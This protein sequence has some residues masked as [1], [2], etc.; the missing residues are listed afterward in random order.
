MGSK[1]S[2]TTTTQQQQTY[3]PT[4]APQIQSALAQGQAAAQ[5]PFNI[6]QAPV[7]GF[8]QDQQNAFQNVNNAQ[9]MAQPYIN[10]A[11]QDFSPQG[12]QNFLNPYASNVMAQMQNI[13]GQQQQ[14]ATGQLTQAAGGVGA[15]R[16][17]VGQGELANQQGLAAG[18]TMS[19][20]YNNAVQ[21]AQGAGYGTAALGSQAQNA[22][23]QGAQAQLGTGGLQQQLSQA[24]MNSPYQWQ[25]AQAAFPYQQAQFNAGITGA[26]APGL[27][28]TTSGTGSTTGPAPSMLSQ[29]LGLGTAAAGVAGGTG[30]FGSGSGSGGKGANPSAAGTPGS[31]YYG[32]VN[33]GG[34]ARGGDV[35][36]D[37]GG[38]TNPYGLPSGFNDKPI[39][40]DQESIVPKEALTP[41]RPNIPQL[42]LNPPAA[43]GG[44]GGGSAVGDVAKIAQM[45]MMFAKRGGRVGY[46]E[47]GEV[48]SSPEDFMRDLR[49]SPTGSARID[50]EYPPMKEFLK[51]LPPDVER[52][53]EGGPVIRLRK[54]KASDLISN[55]GGAVNPYAFAAGG[56][57]DVIN[58]DE[59]YRMADQPSV[60]AWRSGADEAM[61]FAPTGGTRSGND[62]P[63]PLDTAQWPSGPIGG[64][65]DAG[66]AV[67]A[68]A[69]GNASAPGA[70]PPEVPPPQ[71]G[72]KRDHDRFIDSPWA[73]LMAAGLGI[74]GGTSPFA[75]VNI[76]QGGLQG[77]K[78]LQEQRGSAQKDETIDQAAKRL[79][80]EAKHHEDQYSRMTPGQKETLA[81]HKS[82]MAL[83]ENKPI[84]VGI[85]AMGHDIL[86]I[87]DKDTGAYVDP[88]TRKPVQ[89]PNARPPS[90]NIPQGGK[91]DDAAL[92]P[93]AQLTE[94]VDIPEGVDKTVLA[95]ISPDVAKTVRAIDE[96]RANL[97][98]IPMKDR[99]AYLKL[100]NEYDPAWD[101]NLY[102]LRK[103]QN[104]DMS[105]QGNAGKMILAVNQLLPHLKKASDDA[106][107][108]NNTGYP[109]ANTIKNWWLTQTGDPR[110]KQFEQV[111]EVAAMDVAR[112]LR[113]SGQ[114]AEK[115]IDFWRQ[116]FASADSPKTM[117]GL[118][119][120]LA[121]DLMG[122][123]IGSIQQSYRMNMRKEPPDFV[124]KE[125]KEALAGIK[126]RQQPAQPQ[127]VPAAGAPVPAAG[128]AA[129]AKPPTVVQNGHTYTLQPDGSYK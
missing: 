59:P 90:Y 111:R 66:A 76:G 86:G 98:S 3:N 55:R 20:L 30:M 102:S 116:S 27:G 104:D 105:T 58:P 45:A 122:A 39:N 115:D 47:G 23:L 12:A 37:E 61:K 29:I 22:A 13:F 87:R 33:S 101:Q 63:S 51:A 15:D 96:G 120:Q 54:N 28:G 38:S 34:Y 9:G 74:A 24:Q 49:R 114:M 68:F 52:G 41:I 26:L 80:L 18:Q 72:S 19:G 92:P 123:R 14:Q 36:Y 85:D 40:V 31:P 95:R 4:G 50:P 56:D 118:I 129:P 60:N 62:K 121:D 88:I 73:A 108:L 21:Q 65:S 110:V 46:A 100:V 8:S 6:P 69:P 43:S 2:N 75:G 91:E 5:L 53:D 1:G 35:G 124:S 106:E 89:D 128:G 57:T 125:A 97:S 112:L 82:Q 79:E 107:K 109:A 17:A 67:S 44:G 11:Q 83:N 126:T 77:L 117:Q 48:A 84:K 25:L 70:N 99:A 32:P 7:A 103:R 94:G 71:T 81:L 127:A 93:H 119:G 64:P 113:G 42:N 10:Q 78:T 16:I